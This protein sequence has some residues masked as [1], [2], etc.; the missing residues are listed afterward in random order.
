MSGAKTTIVT[1][2]I[3]SLLVSV[4]LVLALTGN[5][6]DSVEE[7]PPV[8]EETVSQPDHVVTPVQFRQRLSDSISYQR[9]NIIT[10]TVRRVSPA[11]VG[12]DIKE[13]RQYRSPW[14]NDPFWRYFFGS[15][16][17]N[18][19]IQ[20]IGSGAIISSDGYII[21]NDHVAGTADEIL[22]TLSNGEQYKAEIVGTDLTTDI[23]LLKIDAENLPFVRLGNSDDIIIGEWSIAI[24]N[25]FGLF[26]LSDHPTVTV[27]VVS[28]LGMNLSAIDDRYYMN[29]IQTD[30][31]IN[32]GNS[33]GP[34]VNSMGEMI[35][36]NTIIFTT[37]T[38]TGSLGVGF[39]IPVNKVRRIIEELK[40]NGRIDRNYWT[41][42]TVRDIDQGIADYFDLSRARGVII[43]EL[44]KNSPAE[45]AGLQVYD[46]ITEI[47]GYKIDNT[48]V[49]LGILQ[50]YKTGD[51]ITFTIFR[52]GEKQYK[53]M[54]LMR[55]T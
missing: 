14:S 30:A 16:V 34:L 52:D 15:G 54:Q 31:S 35:G 8:I 38:S 3:T 28:A 2:I 12:I 36:M 29:M 9:Q 22:V 49:L 17:Y 19:K 5:Q 41:G 11:V 51:K 50:D 27:G 37:N 39:A 48:D 46:I 18:K 24:G 6:T 21:T 1:S 43:N 47:N 26:S 40:E 4:T 44:A 10:E 45:E 13:I 25:P 42:L 55:K 32:Q 33:G 7:T 23:C 20:G 53:V